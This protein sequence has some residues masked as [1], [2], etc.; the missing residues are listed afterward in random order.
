MQ[1]RAEHLNLL[2]FY[3][4]LIF[5]CQGHMTWSCVQRALK[6]LPTK[7]LGLFKK[8]KHLFLGYLC[9]PC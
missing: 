1:T 9:I 3:S 4:H 5:H 8:M 6:E 2:S 7:H